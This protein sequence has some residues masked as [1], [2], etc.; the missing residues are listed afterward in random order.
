MKHV[1]NSF[2][3]A[4]KYNNI[5]Y[6]EFIKLAPLEGTEIYRWA[7]NNEFLL[8]LNN[9]N[10][11]ESFILKGNKINVVTPCFPRYQQIITLKI[12]KIISFIVSYNYY[13]K[14]HTFHDSIKHL[15]VLFLPKNSNQIIKK[16]LKRVLK[17]R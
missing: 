9:N 17:K 2:K 7:L 15:I 12:A 13:Q 3:F 10:I 1:F 4:L 11:F 5:C 8:D 6:V 16:I 14:N